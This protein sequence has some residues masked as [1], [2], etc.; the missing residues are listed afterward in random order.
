[1]DRR[2]FI[3]ASVGMVAALSIPTMS[4]WRELLPSGYWAD[5]SRE[6]IMFKGKLVERII[7]MTRIRK[8]QFAIAFI[9]NDES[10]FDRRMDSLRF[11][12]NCAIY[13]Q[14]E[15]DGITTYKWDEVAGRIENYS[16]YF[17]ERKGIL[18]GKWLKF[19]MKPQK[20]PPAQ[21]YRPRPKRD[22]GRKR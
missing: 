7:V 21:S 8:R 10:Q 6:N 11:S 4:S 12:L 17:D 2:K 18:M 13:Q 22:T 20:R 19:P 1:M 16:E 14:D 15:K 3:G 5:F 9:N